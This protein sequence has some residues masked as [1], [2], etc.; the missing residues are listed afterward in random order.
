M[1]RHLCSSIP[2]LAQALAPNWPDLNKFR[3]VDEQYKQKFMR[4][5]DRHHHVCELPVLDDQVPVYI[6]SERSTSAIPGSVVR[7]AGEQSC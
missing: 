3:E 1:V 4:Q 6:S 2:T 7:S 5:H